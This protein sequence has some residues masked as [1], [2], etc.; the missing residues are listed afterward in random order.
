[1]SKNGSH[2]RF[3][4]RSSGNRKTPTL[5][6]AL[7][8]SEGLGCF[9]ERWHQLASAMPP[10]KFS[11]VVIDPYIQSHAAVMGLMKPIQNRQTEVWLFLWLRRYR[12]L[13]GGRRLL[14]SVLLDFRTQ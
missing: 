9:D 7:L 11:S 5:V 14:N 6:S 8:C 1:M 10:R 12:D 4:S 13:W 3:I 2:N